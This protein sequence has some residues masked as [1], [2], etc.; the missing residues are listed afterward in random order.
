MT[1]RL[2]VAAVALMAIVSASCAS[3]EE[4]AASASGSSAS[5]ASAGKAEYEK[6]LS[7]AKDAQK[8]A[9]SVGG[10]WRDTG[11]MLTTAEEAAAKG[12]YAG[13][14]KMANKA[15]KQAE[16]GYSQAMGQKDAGP[17]L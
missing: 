11:K 6:A 8:K 3:K 7:A 1:L 13:A 12:D 17:R 9:A 14:T 5:V 2:T 10:E 15:M 16:S 4:P